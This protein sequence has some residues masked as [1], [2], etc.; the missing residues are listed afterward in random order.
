MPTRRRVSTINLIIIAVIV[1][2][3]CVPFVG[4]RLKMM[5]ANKIGLFLVVGVVVLLFALS[6]LGGEHKAR[7]L[8]AERRR[9]QL[10]DEKSS[11]KRK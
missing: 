9:K 6:R 5:M 4:F 7:R 10:E 3:V 11:R 2:M 1:M 8:E